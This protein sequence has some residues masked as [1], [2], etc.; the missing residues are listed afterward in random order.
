MWKLFTR[1]ESHQPPLEGFDPKEHDTKVEALKA[2]CLLI[3][4]QVHMKILYIAGPNDGHIDER[5]ILAWCKA[6]G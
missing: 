2:A 6:Q 3:R 4:T 5:E 1:N